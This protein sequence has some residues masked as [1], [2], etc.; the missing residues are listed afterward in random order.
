M[1]QRIIQFSIQ[2]KLIIA[3]LTLALI[4]WGIYSFLQVPLD[5]VPDITN[6]QVQVVTVSST[7]ST[8]EVEKFITQPIERNVANLQGV[9]QVRS[10]SR[11][12]LSVVTIVF[13]DHIPTLQARQ[14]VSEKL[15]TISNEIPAELGI[16]ELMPITTGLGEIFQ[17]VLQVKPG[18]E[19][20]FSLAELRTIQDWIVKKQMAGMEGIVE[21][22][23]FGGYLKQYE[24]AVDPERLSSMDITL[25]EVIVA[26]SANNANTGASYMEKGENSL[27][28]RSEGM[29]RSLD[30]IGL[31]F[32]KTVNGVPVYVKDVA[33][34]IRFGH[35]KRFG[36]MTMDGKGEVVGG[37]TLMLKGANSYNVVAGVKERI[38]KIQQSLPEGVV[39]MP[40]IDRATLIDKT[41][42]TVSKNLL[43][44]GLIV[45]FVLVILLGN[46]RAGV[47]V[48]SVIPL[49]MLFAFGMMNVFGVSANLMS[50]GALDFGL[51]VDGAVVVVEGIIHQLHRKYLG[52]K[53]SREEMDYTVQ[54]FAGKI[55]RS[56]VFGQIIILIVYMPIMALVGI[57]G[58]MFK[59]MALTVSFA[60]LGAII[61]SLTYVPMLSS[62]LISR[63]IKHHIT[64]S[65]RIM[66]WIERFYIITLKSII[67]MKYWVIGLALIVFIVSLFVFT[68]LGSVFIPTLEEGD[69]AM[70]M[71]MVPGTSLQQVIHT[72]SIVEEKLLHTFPEVKHV[73]SKIGTA[74]VPT[75]PMGMEDTD[76]MI[77]LKPKSEWVSA[78][79][80]EA[81]VDK[82]KKKLEEIPGVSF[83]FSQPIQL[84]FNE[85]MT[86]SKADIAVKIFGDDMEVLFDQANKAASII[87]NIQGAADIKVEQV[88]GLPQLIVKPDRA[89]L[90]RYGIHIDDVNLAVRTAFAGEP[91]SVV[92]EGERKF[93][94]VVRYAKHSREDVEVFNRMYLR[95]ITGELIPLSSVCDIRF[96]KGPMLI[97]RENAQRRIVI[98]I[99]VRNRDIQ[100][101][102]TEIQSKLQ[103]G[104]TL[105]EGYYITYGG[106]FENLQHA[107]KRLS[108]AVPAGLL[109]IFILLFFAF[110]SLKDAVMIYT[111]VPLAAIGGIFALLI[112]GMPFSISAG[113]G[114]IALFGVAV[115]N[116]IVLIGFF[117]QLESEGKHNVY[118][119]VLEGTK[120]RLRPVLMT[121]AVASLG[122]I[123]MAISQSAGGE[124]QRP[125]A[126]VVIGGLI[127][128]TLLT[129][130]LLPIIYI[131]FSN[132]PKKLVSPVVLLILAVLFQLP[133]N[134]QQANDTLRIDK[135]KLVQAALE[136]YPLLK[137]SMLE[138][139][140]SKANVASAWDVPNA[141]FQLQRGQI[142]SV[143]VDNY[144]TL[145]QS[146]GNL[147]YNSINTSYLKQRIQLMQNFSQQQ[148]LKLKWQ[149]LG[150]YEEMVAAIQKYRWLKEE[151]D[152]LKELSRIT[153]LQ[154]KQGAT[155]VLTDIAV[156]RML[157]SSDQTLRKWQAGYVEMMNMMQVLT[158]LTQFIIP[159]NDS[160]LLNSFRLLLE[161][162]IDS[163]T[164]PII[165]QYII[166]K[167]LAKKNYQVQSSSFAPTLNGGY[168]NQQLDHVNGFQGF[169]VGV[170]I[171][172]FSAKN[173]SEVKKAKIQIDQAEN[174][175]V[176]QSKRLHT[177]LKTLKE[178]TLQS[179]QNIVQFQNQLLPDAQ[180][181]IEQARKKYLAGDIGFYEF[182][183]HF[184]Q[185]NAVRY[186][187][188]D[189]VL[190]YNQY[191]LAYAYLTGKL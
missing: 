134:A 26:L 8:E 116:G 16:P 50:L 174:E 115:L 2:Q 189:E 22:S 97:S 7:L 41:I 21:I 170:G 188:I 181:M 178:K 83:E 9:K 160:L 158:G 106:E 145:S 58:K 167:N 30:E 23:S 3:L 146:L 18:Y 150:L 53:L 57:E 120:T 95:S 48:A 78:S 64:I 79:S 14:L 43:E 135:D 133:L 92:Y 84:R 152:I 185:A 184:T 98:G 73:V 182:Q 172:L 74:E 25:D 155:D 15:Q 128:S 144:F 91:V 111:A 72:T 131:I 85:L 103:K 162:N 19:N 71:T 47:I 183:L 168:F 104:L 63:R 122:F 137:N 34:E 151:N 51:V 119:R 125:L 105:P 62:V 139:N 117:K 169:L 38:K 147:V 55:M 100:S 124:V 191:V 13:D 77:I 176:Y 180:R 52:K 110:G 154:Q 187:F 49:S 29:I 6:N 177:E 113:V 76:I 10:I 33:S 24:V 141:E 165:Q 114:F 17:Y 4:V 81:L 96:A 157:A 109:L 70:Q 99:N 56:A 61:L 118:R 69:L 166:E 127:T 130:I 87:S 45:V 54:S 12:G 159:S 20:R 32:I 28:I 161:Q 173:Y 179:Y 59:P 46:L 11:F 67:R 42:H 175:L 156:K 153:E 148:E 90:A 94:M 123:P 190:L 140:K 82:M 66:G 88:E 149:V 40:F 102:V 129:L 39:I 143:L 37:I 36:A 163:T 136:Y 75:D 132:K 112:R 93:D 121:A 27:F 171:P 186:S 35:A 44:G 101:L 65:D 164:Y 86:G 68:R 60:I 1:I 126:T 5:A 80:R 108:I 138:V 142:N 89:Q 107:R 31:I